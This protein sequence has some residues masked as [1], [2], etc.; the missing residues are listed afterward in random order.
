MVGSVFAIFHKY[1]KIAIVMY[2]CYDSQFDRKP[3]SLEWALVSIYPFWSAFHVDFETT[4]ISTLE[5]LNCDWGSLW[6]QCLSTEIYL[7]VEYNAR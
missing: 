5:K 2:G 7:P 1:A 6:F 3:L 4:N